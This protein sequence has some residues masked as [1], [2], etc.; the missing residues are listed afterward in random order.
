MHILANVGVRVPVNNTEDRPKQF[1][2]YFLWDYVDGT[3]KQG[4]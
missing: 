2:I 1:L 3:L 4:W